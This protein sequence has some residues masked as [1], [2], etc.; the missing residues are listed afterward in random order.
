MS[1]GEVAGQGG[2]LFLV[3]TRVNGQVSV[4]VSFADPAVSNSREELLESLRGAL[5][6]FRLSGSVA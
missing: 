5:A 6:D 3:S 1:A 4:T 2:L